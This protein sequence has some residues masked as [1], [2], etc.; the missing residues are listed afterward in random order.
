MIVRPA[1]DRD[2]DR[3]I[4][5]HT[6]AFPDAR[7]YEARVR[8]FKSNPFGGLE[9]LRVV[10]DAGAIVGHAC[11]YATEAWFG[12]R[13]VRCGAI[14]S[15]GAAP[16]ARRRGVAAA[17]LEALHEESRARGDAITILHAFRQGFYAKHGYAPA[18]PYK[19]LRVSP[20][21]VPREWK[22]D[23][24]RAMRAKDRAA[25]EAAYARAAERSTGFIARRPAHWEYRFLDERRVWL[26]VER[27]RTIAGY[28]SWSLAQAEAHA[29]TTMR[30]R[31]LVADDDDARRALLA[32]IGAQRDQ[33]SEATIDT[34]LDDPLDLAL[35]DA[36]QARF[37]TAELEHALGAIAAGPMVRLADR[38]RALEARGVKSPKNQRSL[39]DADDRALA[40]VLFGGVAPGAAARLGWASA[41]VAKALAKLAIPPYFALDPF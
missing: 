8:N 33:V 29:E 12:G 14:A 26:V 25:I 27:E 22:P 10:E 20:R 3:V 7:G 31:D 17:L 6:S 39:A 13:L 38:A 35:V 15:V 11:L 37:G 32:A 23:G 1:R 24:V 21:A 16:E 4:A 28:V 41:K 5:V 30:V 36:D 19:Q 40:A 18:A 34:A 9:A 2:L